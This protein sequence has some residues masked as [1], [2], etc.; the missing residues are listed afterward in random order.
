MIA[1]T[2]R[3]VNIPVG[4]AVNIRDLTKSPVTFANYY[5]ESGAGT[6]EIGKSAA[7]AA[8][9]GFPV[10]PDQTYTDRDQSR[11]RFMIATGAPVNVIVEEFEA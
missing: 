8:G 9:Q 3:I 7:M 10:Q 2:P 1:R 11:E 4:A 5:Y 6:V